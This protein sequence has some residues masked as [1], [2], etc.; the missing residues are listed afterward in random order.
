MVAAFF[1]VSGGAYG[2]E[3]VVRGAGYTRAILILFVTPIIWSL[4][5]AYMIG[6][7]SSALPRKAAFTSVGT[8]RHGRLFG[9]SGSVAFAGR[10]YL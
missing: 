4:P 10:Q 5:T 3:D 9:L 8:P 6:E 1:M 7:L 2:I